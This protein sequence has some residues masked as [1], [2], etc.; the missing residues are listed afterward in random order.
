MEDN[1]GFVDPELKD[2]I[3]LMLRAANKLCEFV[4]VRE[5]LDDCYC[6]LER[7]TVDWLRDR[8]SMLL[9]PDEGW[10]K[11]EGLAEVIPFVPR[12]RG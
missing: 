7:K 3:D 4:E 9:P 11:G 5:D 8:A 2:A 10:P 1:D 12:G 6:D